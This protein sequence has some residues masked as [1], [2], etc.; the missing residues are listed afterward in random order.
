MVHQQHQ[1]VVRGEGRRDRH[2]LALE[3]CM[4]MCV[5]V[6]VCVY[7]EGQRE[8]GDIKKGPPYIHTYMHTSILRQKEREIDRDVHAH[9]HTPTHTHRDTYLPSGK[10]VCEAGDGG[11]SGFVCV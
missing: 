1:R 5:C 11:R 8:W 7:R 10:E 3:V 4:C 2:V 9:I 6:C